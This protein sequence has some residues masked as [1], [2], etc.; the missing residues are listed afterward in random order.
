MRFSLR[1]F[2]LFILVV[3][4]L[5]AM[6]AWLT[7]VPAVETTQPS[8]AELESLA[9]EGEYLYRVA[10]CV[11]CHTVDEDGAPELAGGRPLETAFGV[12]HG[13][14]ISPDTAAGI[15]TWTAADFVRALRHGRSP[16]GRAYYPSFP[17]TSYAAMDEADMVRLYAYIM[18]RVPASDAPSLDH[19]LAWYLN[20]SLPARIWQWLFFEP[21]PVRDETRDVQWNRGSYLAN[22]LLHCGECHTPR[23]RLGVPHDGMYLAGWDAGPEGRHTPNITPDEKTGIGGWSDRELSRFLRFGMEP[24]GDFVGSGMGEVID[25]LKQLSDDDRAALMNYLRNIP[26]IETETAEP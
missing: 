20:T 13:P 14:N 18:K 26:A 21:A 1:R 16:D 8:Q 11:S 2:G 3:A 15:G 6:F 5:V 23:N 7:A 9:V 19:E 25:H 17:Y 12:F 10:G 4:V 22:A 24:G